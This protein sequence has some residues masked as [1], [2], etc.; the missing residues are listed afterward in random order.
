LHFN[1]NRDLGRTP[2]HPI[3]DLE[4]GRAD[5]HSPTVLRRHG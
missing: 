2:A 1:V 5:V 4:Q 3:V